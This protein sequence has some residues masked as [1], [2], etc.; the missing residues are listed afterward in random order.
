MV[1]IVHSCNPAVFLH[2]VPA[3][4]Q[5][6]IV[7]SGIIPFDCPGSKQSTFADCVGQSDQPGSRT[8]LVLA[9]WAGG[10]QPAAGPPGS[11]PARCPPWRQTAQLQ[12]PLEQGTPLEHPDI[13]QPQPPAWPA[14]FV[15]HGDWGPG[16]R[17]ASLQPSSHSPQSLAPAWVP[18]QDPQNGTHSSSM[19]SVASG[20]GQQCSRGECEGMALPLP[21]L[22][23]FLT[24]ETEF[25]HVYGA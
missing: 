15:W 1:H 11:G 16:P 14:A 24:S 2:C 17:P 20:S 21:P 13:T 8:T 4:L 18:V 19:C 6:R 12:S 3:S 5:W 7:A 9:F 10:R 22:R 25:E 23:F